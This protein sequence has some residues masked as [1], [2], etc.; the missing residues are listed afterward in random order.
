MSLSAYKKKAGKKDTMPQQ[1][2]DYGEI[3]HDGP[4]FSYA[5]YQSAPSGNNYYPGSYGQKLTG[6]ASGMTATPGQRL[7]L[8]IISIAMLI[9]MTFGLIG[10]AVATQAPDWA[11]FPILFILTLFYSAVVI[12]N[13]VF[14]RKH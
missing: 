13:I 8:A 12:I 9:I 3:N 6:Q 2:M 11:I 4:N 14:N 5:G 10:F 1:E 7:A